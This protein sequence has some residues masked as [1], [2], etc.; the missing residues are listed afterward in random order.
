MESC[1]PR[2]LAPGLSAAYG[3]SYAW[4]RS[5][6]TSEAQRSCSMARGPT[7]APLALGGFGAAISHNLE[8]DALLGVQLHEYRIANRRPQRRVTTRKERTRADLHLEIECFTQKYLL[9]HAPLPDVGTLGPRLRQLHVL[10]PHREHH[11]LVQPQGLDGR[12]LDVADLGT[13]DVAALLRRLPPEDRALD[14]VSG[15]HE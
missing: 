13:H 12:H 2:K 6:I 5:T 10:G 3:R 15:A 11:A 14:E 7:P 8:G 9:V 1:R 4:S